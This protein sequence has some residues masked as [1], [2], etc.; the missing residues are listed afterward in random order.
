V[1]SGKLKVESKM[2]KNI[3]IDTGTTACAMAVKLAR[4]EVI[5]AYPITPQT[6]ISEKLASFVED[7]EFVSRYIA[8]ESEHS[9]IS[10]VAA[11]SAAGSRT[12]TATSSQGLLYMH[13]IL[14]YAAGGRLPIVLVN[15]NR[16]INAPWCLYVD[17]QDTL[18]Q[19]DTGWLQLYAGDNQEIHDMTILA[20]KIAEEAMIPTM[21]CFDGFLLSHSMLPFEP[22]TEKMVKEFLPDRDPEWCLMP[23]YGRK[24][25]ASVTPALEYAKYREGLSKDIRKAKA[26]IKKRGHEL[27]KLTG[28]KSLGLLS[29]YQ[30]K[31]ADLFIVSLGSM[32]V[33]AEIAIDSLRK[34]GIKAGGIRP[35][36]FRPFP[37]EEISKVVPDGSTV[38][39]LDRNYAYGTEGGILLQ[40]LKQSFYERGGSVK[41]K[42]KSIGVGGMELPAEYIEKE[43]MGVYEK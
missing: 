31:G 29:E 8:V 20:Y 42:G 27:D 10:A 11:A 28:H 12:F 33:E 30:T 36:V 15:V 4:P 37:G 24:T 41:L 32:G 26:L 35:K 3:I 19:R 7:G 25:F 5:A 6:S 16:A 39:A 34:K 23:E 14:H 13:E 40:E 22:M 9:A 18:S 2:K 1:E 17:H 43:I 38:I 21:L